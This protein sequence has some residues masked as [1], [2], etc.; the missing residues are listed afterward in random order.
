MYPKINYNVT[1]GAVETG[2]GLK[3]ELMYTHT[4]CKHYAL[5]S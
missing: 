3:A 1:L 5:A 2:L 4:N